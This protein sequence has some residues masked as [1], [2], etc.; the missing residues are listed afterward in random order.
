MR[1]LPRYVNHVR[2]CMGVTCACMCTST[3]TCIYGHFINANFNALTTAYTCLFK[4][5]I[6]IIII[7]LVLVPGCV[8]M[9]KNQS[10]CAIANWQFLLAI[11]LA[12]FTV[13][14]LTCA[15]RDIGGLVLFNYIGCA[16][17]LFAVIDGQRRRVGEILILFYQLLRFRNSIWNALNASSNDHNNEL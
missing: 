6:L 3:F 5:S 15:I 11:F 4:Y 9:H 14:Y 10:I 2:P 12:W 7:S 17:V 13:W 16:T 8:P 1:K